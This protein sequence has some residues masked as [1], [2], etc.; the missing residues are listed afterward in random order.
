MINVK[1]RLN[2][3]VRRGFILLILGM[4]IS[5][6]I[7]FNST[8]YFNSGGLYLI[9]GVVTIGGYLTWDKF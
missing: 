9:L 7:M 6:F 2:Q 8:D 3:D 4:I 1:M 5:L